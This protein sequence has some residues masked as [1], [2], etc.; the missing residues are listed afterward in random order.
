MINI[1]N[2]LKNFTAHLKLR[3]NGD[4]LEPLEIH[5]CELAGHATLIYAKGLRQQYPAVYARLRRYA[6]Q[7]G[8]TLKEDQRS[9]QHQRHNAQRKPWMATI[10]LLC[11]VGLGGSHPSFADTPLDIDVRSQKLHAFANTAPSNTDLYKTPLEEQPPA[12][13]SND[14]DAI[15]KLAEI[16]RRHWQPSVYDPQSMPK[17]IDLLAEYYSQYPEVRRLIYALD[18][19]TWRLNYAREKHETNIHGT[20]LSVS[21][22]D[23]FFDPRTA[24]QFK[25]NSACKDMR[26]H[27]V[28]SPADVLLHELLHVYLAFSDTDT[29]IAHGGM[30][31][32]T[33]PFQHEQLTIANE[34]SLYSSMKRVDGRARPLRHEHSGRHRASLCVTCIR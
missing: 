11:I 12:D 21:S 15:A 8:L 1:N 14:P 10:S 26:S 13:A 16:L 5:P 23:V 29:F 34:R 33:Y 4:A 28:A 6:I 9:S 17:D 24:T 20:R 19:Y 3:T 2:F 27:C 22:A 25:F 32:F 18:K 31:S 7:G 30:T